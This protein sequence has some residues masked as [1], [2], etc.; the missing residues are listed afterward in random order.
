[1]V[2]TVSPDDRSM[3]RHAPAQRTPP[4]PPSSQT[5]RGID[6]RVTARVLPGRTRR[7]IWQA[8]GA[9]LALLVGAAVSAVISAAISLCGLFGEQCT[10]TE[11]TQMSLLLL[12]AV[13]LLGATVPTAWLLLPR[14]RRD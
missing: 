11:N 12:L 3:D 4:P 14:H 13:T 7:Q 6:R 2:P 8:V 9:V 1:M 10:D 5:A